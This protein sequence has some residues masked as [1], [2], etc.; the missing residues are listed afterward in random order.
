MKYNI[1]KAR[2]ATIYL[3]LWPHLKKSGVVNEH[4]FAMSVRKLL[5]TSE[6]NLP[7]FGKTSYPD[8]SYLLTSFNWA[9]SPQGRSYWANM[10]SIAKQCGLNGC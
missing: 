2:T 6:F 5:N 4:K 9:S 10:Y 1:A 7:K 8:A 3:I